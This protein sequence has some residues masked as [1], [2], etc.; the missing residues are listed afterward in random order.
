MVL[1][2]NRDNLKIIVSNLKDNISRFALNLNVHL[3]IIL[4]TKK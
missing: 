3:K 2:Y 4:E 1:S